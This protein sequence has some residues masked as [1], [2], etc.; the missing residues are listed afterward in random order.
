MKEPGNFEFFSNTVVWY[1]SPEIAIFSYD[2][3]T[4]VVVFPGICWIE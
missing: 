4:A 3:K 2:D 1:W